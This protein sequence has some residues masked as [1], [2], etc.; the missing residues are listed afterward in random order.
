M[1][2]S[3]ALRTLSWCASALMVRGRCFS[4]H[5]AYESVI[6]SLEETEKS[7]N[8]ARTKTQICR[9]AVCFSSHLPLRL[10]LVPPLGESVPPG[11][12]RLE[13]RRRRVGYDTIYLYE[14]G[15]LRQ[16]RESGGG[17]GGQMETKGGKDRNCK[18]EMA[19]HRIGASRNECHGDEKFES[20][21]VCEASARERKG[22]QSVVGEVSWSY[23]RFLHESCSCLLRVDCILNRC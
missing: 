15:S 5:G 9:R 14:R 13:D 11:H 20:T 19:M 8:T 1:N 10:L 18:D 22:K 3:K 23:G 2:L 21:E 17:G 4:D 16:L 7:V 12:V 6:S